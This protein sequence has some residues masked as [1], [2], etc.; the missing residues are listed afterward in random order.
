MTGVFRLEILTG[1]WGENVGK[2]GVVRLESGG[3]ERNLIIG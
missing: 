3:I 1:G 2:I